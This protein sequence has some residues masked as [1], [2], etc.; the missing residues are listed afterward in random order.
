MIP[1]WLMALLCKK[2]KNKV[3]D[4]SNTQ[5]NIITRTEPNHMVKEMCY[6]CSKTPYTYVRIFDHRLL[7]AEYFHQPDDNMLNIMKTHGLSEME[8]YPEYWIHL[9]QDLILT[10]YP[11]KV[12]DECYQV[13]KNNQ[14]Y[15]WNIWNKIDQKS[16]TV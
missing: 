9:P 16:G 6:R 3:H 12:C 1:K 10:K 15:A 13:A 5:D 2:K 7:P 14:T 4:T 8:T 11:Y